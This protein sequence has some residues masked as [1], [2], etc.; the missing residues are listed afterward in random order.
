MTP[1][2]VG[3]RRR[4]PLLG[5]INDGRDEPHPNPAGFGTVLGIVLGVLTLSIVTQ[6]IGFTDIDRNLSFLIIG[7]FLLTV[8]MLARRRARLGSD[9]GKG[10]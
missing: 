10:V 7:V 8:W 9:A 4:R 1:R 3:R 6:A 2:V 5:E